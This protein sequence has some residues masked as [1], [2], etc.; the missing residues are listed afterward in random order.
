MRNSVK[1]FKQF[2]DT[3]FS[4]GTDADQAKKMSGEAIADFIYYIPEKLDLLES[5]QEAGQFELLYQTVADLKFLIEFS[6]EISRYWYV[7]R[8]YSGA[9]AKLK[10]DQTVKGSK[11]VYG[12][13]FDR[14]GDRRMLREEHWFEKKRWEFLDELNSIFSESELDRFM[15]KYTRILSD[16]LHVFITNV[17]LFVIELKNFVCKFDLPEIS[18]S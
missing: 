5:Y 10:A 3:S 8:G 7:V 1:S 13:Y 14:Y 16:D 18:K 17:M 9:L 11:R 4:L 2:Y 12:Y 15:L 6:N